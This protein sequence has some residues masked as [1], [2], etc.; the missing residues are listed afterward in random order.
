MD[1]EGILYI[2]FLPKGVLLAVSKR[3]FEKLHKV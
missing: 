3:N 1:Y 2:T